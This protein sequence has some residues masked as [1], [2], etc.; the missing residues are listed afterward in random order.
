MIDKNVLCAPRHVLRTPH[1]ETKLSCFFQN[2]IL[3]VGYLITVLGSG[4]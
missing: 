2:K 4:N 3:T 1:R